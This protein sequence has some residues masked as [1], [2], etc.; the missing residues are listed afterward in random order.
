MQIADKTV[1]GFDYHLTNDDGEVL[2]TS[3]DRQPLYYLHG[4][5][6]IIPGLHAKMEGHSAGDEFEV[7]IDPADAYGERHDGLCQDVDRSQFDEIEDLTL[8]MQFRVATEDGQPIT[9]TVV[10]IGAETV[11]VD[12]NHPLAGVALTFRIAVR[13]VREAT[14]EEVQHGHVHGPGGHEH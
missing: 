10:E 7:R 9:L 6:G 13:E 3:K 2:D 12:G 8:G 1:V 11:K 14:E 4:S 5:G